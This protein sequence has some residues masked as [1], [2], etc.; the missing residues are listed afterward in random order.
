M[1][2]IVLNGG[3]LLIEL[4]HVV[5]VHESD[6]ADDLAIWGF[7]S[8]F[9]QFVADQIAKGLGAVGVAA[10]SDEAIELVQQV[11]VDGDAN[12]AQAAHC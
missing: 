4:P 2:V 12:S 10:F 1:V 3:Q 5:V 7:P 11:A 9:D 6:G 8:L